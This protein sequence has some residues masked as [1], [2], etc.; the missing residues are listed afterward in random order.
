MDI[1]GQSE[2]ESISAGPIMEFTVDLEHPENSSPSHAIYGDSPFARWGNALIA[3][4]D[5]P[6]DLEG[7]EFNAKPGERF[8]V[9]TAAGPVEGSRA[10][11]QDEHALVLIDRA[12]RHTIPWDDIQ[13]VTTTG[14][15]VCA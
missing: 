11:V 7:W 4:A 2:T 6:W 8:V 14:S 5:R 1:H 12:T 13:N 10:N 15:P 9:T 3:A